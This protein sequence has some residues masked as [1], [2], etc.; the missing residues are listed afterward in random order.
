MGLN[1]F[2][3][4]N[5][6]SLPVS[7]LGVLDSGVPSAFQGLS[8]IAY[9]CHRYSLFSHSVALDDTNLLNP[10]CFKYLKEITK[11]QHLLEQRVAP[12]WYINRTYEDRQPPTI[13]WGLW[14]GRR[15][16]PVSQRHGGEGLLQFLPRYPCLVPPF[17]PPH[18]NSDSRTERVLPVFLNTHA[19]THT[20][21]ASRC[22]YL[23]DHP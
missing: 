6:K 4:I 10:V 1:H 18:P 15:G 23:Q 21:S 2:L 12:L 7:A 11:K 3:K 5:F 20:P 9:L 8:I 19:H 22:F 17:Q 14:I 13:P 16:V